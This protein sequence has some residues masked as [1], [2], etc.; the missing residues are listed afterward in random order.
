MRA[1]ITC[2]HCERSEAIQGYVADIAMDRHDGKSRLAMTMRLMLARMRASQPPALWAHF[3]KF[4]L[5][6]LRNFRLFGA[7]GLSAIVSAQDQSL[8]RRY[9]DQQHDG[10]D[11]HSAN[12]DDRERALHLAANRG[13]KGRGQ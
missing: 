8:K 4:R 1:N 9:E 10:A 13:R 3:A 5:R 11:Q 2:R 7:F 12:H 6:R